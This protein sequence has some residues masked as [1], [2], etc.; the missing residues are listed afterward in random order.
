VVPEEAERDV[1]Q[2]QSVRGVIHQINVWLRG[3][4]KLPLEEARVTRLGIAGD[5]HDDKEDHGGPL[6]ALCL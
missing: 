5:G 3:A 2:D 6:A 4:P 1:M